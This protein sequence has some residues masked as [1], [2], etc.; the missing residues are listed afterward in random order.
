MGGLLAGGFSGGI[1]VHTLELI[2][3]LVDAEGRPV[4]LALTA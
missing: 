4:D 2:H 3:A 1:Q